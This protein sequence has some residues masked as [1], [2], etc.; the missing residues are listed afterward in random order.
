VR[1]LVREIS[2]EDHDSMY[3]ESID[4]KYLQISKQTHAIGI[5]R[6]LVEKYLGLSL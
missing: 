6:G 1:I 5:N 3:L 4:K 2:I